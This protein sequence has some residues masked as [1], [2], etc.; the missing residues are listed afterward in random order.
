MHASSTDTAKRHRGRLPAQRR[1][2]DI[3]AAALACFLARGYAAT[4]IADIRRQ[5]GATTGSIYHFFPGKGALA[6]ALLQQ[7]VAGWTAAGPA[8]ADPDAPGEAAVKGSVR[9]LVAW[10]LEQPALFRFVDEIRTLAVTDPDFVR[11]REVLDRGQAAACARYEAAVAD[12]ICRPLPWP[13]AHSLMLGPAYNFLRLVA[14]GAAAHEA[15]ADL[16]AEAA[17]NSV[18]APA[19]PPAS[20]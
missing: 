6:L 19:S 15:A 14:A 8:A 18:R 11:L 1:R 20:P 12:G 17:W 13:V 3:L 2:D 10:G 9:G 7:A 16:L 4:T 5:S